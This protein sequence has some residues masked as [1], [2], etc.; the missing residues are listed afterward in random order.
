MLTHNAMH[1]V[2]SIQSM[3]EL[4]LK[5][6]ILTVHYLYQISLKDKGHLFPDLNIFVPIVSWQ[7]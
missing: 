3:A 1:S 5:Y 6:N 2:D 4:I 7:T